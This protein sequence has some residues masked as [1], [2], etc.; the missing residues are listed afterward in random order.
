MRVASSVERRSLGLASRRH[1]TRA[2]VGLRSGLTGDLSSQ[3][4]DS[5]R[6]ELES[7]RRRGELRTAR[8]VGRKNEAWAERRLIQILRDIRLNASLG[9][10]IGGRDLDRLN[11]TVGA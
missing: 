2:A 7:L 8:I 3:D 11:V 5:G 9:K 10:E 1:D 4:D 6:S